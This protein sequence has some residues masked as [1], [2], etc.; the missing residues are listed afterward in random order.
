MNNIKTYIIAEA[1]VNHNGNINLAKKLI[2]EAKKCGADAIK[3]QTFKVEN[4]VTK[5]A[6]KATYQIANTKNDKSQFDMLKK[7][8]LN[9][10]AHLILKDY[11]KKKKIDFLS[12]PFDEH[13]FDLLCRLGL[14]TIKIPSG[15]ITN[16]PFLKYI[17]KSGK[18]IILSTGMS[19]L[20]EVK[21]AVNIFYKTG[22]KKISLL[23]CVTEYPA[24]YIQINLRA[25]NTLKKVFKIPVGY[26]DHSEGIEIALAAAAVGAELIEKH[27]T[28][29]RNM[30]GPDHKASIEPA[31]FKRMVESIRNIEKAKGNGIKKPAK[32]EIK[33]IKIVRKSIVAEK[34]ICK[35]EIF[36]KGNISIKR[37]GNGIQPFK[38]DFLLGKISKRN[39]REG[40]LIK[41]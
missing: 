3:F 34:P 26:S 37:P 17:A 32:C 2:R 19:D 18:K 30:K 11:C 33:N 5:N 24:P 25:I 36:T 14:K 39:Y 13:S 6:P 35:G 31:E 20:D 23:H 41:D 1:G 9:W 16:T 22:N 21:T 38:F 10:D 4:L 15:E 12:S 40:D 27:F 7:L 28:L 29:D 8:E